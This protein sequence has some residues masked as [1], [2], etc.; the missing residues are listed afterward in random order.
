VREFYL[1]YNAACNAHEFDRLGE[2]V[3]ADVRVNGER[4]GLDD[5]VAGLRDVVRTWP[6][7]RWNLEDLLIDGDRI[8]ARF[9]DTGTHD[10]TPVRRNEYAFYR[11]A[12]GLI[13]EV[14][15]TAEPPGDPV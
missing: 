2:F 10:G 4:Q 7:Y 5:Y 12:G 9:V 11:V 13:V 1:R 15:V 3:H 6:D 14:W 8:A